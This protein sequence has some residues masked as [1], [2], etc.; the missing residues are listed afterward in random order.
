MAGYARAARAAETAS[1]ASQPDVAAQSPRNGRR[2]LTVACCAHAVLGGFTDD[3]LLLLPIWQG[4]F[5]FSYGEVGFLRTLF[6]GAMATFQIPAGALAARGRGPM[7][8]ALGTAIT[9]PGFLVM[10]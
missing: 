5:G 10:G 3:L 6:S 2:V 8:L 1:L 7:V 4:A 9:G